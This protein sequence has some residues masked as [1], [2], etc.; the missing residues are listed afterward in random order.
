MKPR[1]RVNHPP[2]RPLPPGNQPLTAPIYQSVKFELEDLAETE[3][4]WSGRSEG[5]HYSRHGNPTVHDLKQLLAELQGREDCV[6]V[7]SGVAAV[8]VSLLAPGGRLHVVDFGGQERLPAWFRKALRS[9][10]RRFHV[11]PPD[12][13]GRMLA[14]LCER[15]GAALSFE[16][17]Y[18]GYAQCATVMLTRQPA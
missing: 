14:S 1:T 9:W 2:H 6:A 4:V 5:F 18:R 12:D 17:P 11:T 13:L 10:L 8:A 16:R 3:R 7:G 15:T